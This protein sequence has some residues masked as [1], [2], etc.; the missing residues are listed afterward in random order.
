MPLPSSSAS[1]AAG[2]YW[3]LLQARQYNLTLD[4]RSAMFTYNNRTWEGQA[5]TFQARLGGALP[6][7]NGGWRMAAK[8][9]GSSACTWQWAWHHIASPKCLLHIATPTYPTHPLH[10]THPAPPPSPHAA[11][12]RRLGCPV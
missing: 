6:W 3:E 1:L 5:D 11:L 7:L 10:K 9:G 8:P 4:L 12:H 2:N